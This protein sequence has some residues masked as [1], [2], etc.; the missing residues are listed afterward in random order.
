MKLTSQN[1]ERLIWLGLMLA[2]LLLLKNCGDEGERSAALQARLDNTTKQLATVGDSISNIL[3]KH[4]SDSAEWKGKEQLQLIESKVKDNTVKQQQK[5]I[6]RL[7]APV[8]NPSNISNSS[9][10]VNPD[11]K[12]ACDSLPAEIDKLNIALAEKDTA[13]N[14]LIDLMGYEI[15][16]RD[17]TIGLLRE[18]IITATGLVRDQTS[19]AER[20]INASK[21]RARLLGGIGVIGNERKFLSGAHGHMGYQDRRGKI[22]LASGYIIQVPGMTHPELVYGATILITLIK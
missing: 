10:A 9:V 20:A 1:I 15:D 12:Q 6:D 14:G 21:P 5:T 11:Y 16:Q 8:R 18:Q 4:A 13:I 2:L 3:R 17:S 22:F 19:I 7:L